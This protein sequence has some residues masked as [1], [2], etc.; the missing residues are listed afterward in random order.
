MYDEGKY[1]RSCSLI[2]FIVIII[3]II[4]FLSHE[5]HL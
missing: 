3:I 4:L 5:C 1:N 2:L